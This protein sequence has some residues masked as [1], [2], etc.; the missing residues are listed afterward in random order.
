M[1]DSTGKGEGLMLQHLQ[2]AE[3]SHLKKCVSES[4]RVRKHRVTGPAKMSQ[5]PL[6]QRLLGLTAL[7]GNCAQL[8]VV[9]VGT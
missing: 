6:R 2:C 3:A 4:G 5:S 9:G 8:P 1:T 7:D